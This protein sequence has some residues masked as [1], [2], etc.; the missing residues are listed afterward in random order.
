MLGGVEE[1]DLVV[2]ARD[3]FGLRDEAGGVVAAAFGRAG[4]AGR[5]A[6]IV[7]DPDRHGG[8]AG[9]EIVARRAGDDEVFVLLGRAHAEEGLGGDHEGA[10]IERAA[11]DGGE[12][13]AVGAHKLLD[14]FEEQRLGQRGHGEPLG[15]LVEPRGIG[16]G[17]EQGNAAVLLA[18][19]LQPL[20]DFLRIMQHCGG[21]IERDGL[22]RADGRIM[23]AA[24]FVPFDR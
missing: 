9:L 13:V 22:A 6:G 17:A 20:E 8:R 21:G 19:G 16:L 1:D 7:A 24:P 3:R 5:G 12:P 4:A 10:Q 23:P 15:G 2:A 11:L 18:I 14:A